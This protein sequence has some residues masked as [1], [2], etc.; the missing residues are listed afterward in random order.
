MGEDEPGKEIGP[1]NQSLDGNFAWSKIGQTG[2]TRSVNPKEGT[3]QRTYMD[4]WAGGS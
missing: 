2:A 1:M 4:V 3:K